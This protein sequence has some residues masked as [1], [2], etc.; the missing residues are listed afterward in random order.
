MEERS[1]RVYGEKTFFSRITNTI[2]KLLIPTKVGINGVLIS[3]KRN[4]VL[5]VYDSY[6]NIDSINNEEKKE[7]I[8][9][10]FDDAYALYLESIDKY[11]MD[12]IYKKVR[13]RTAT[14]FEENALSRYYQIVHI[15]EKEYLEYKYRKQMYLLN[16]DYENVNSG[17]KTQIIEKYKTLYFKEMESLYKGLLK[18]F[19]IKLADNLTQANKEEI[20]NKIFEALEEYIENIL[21]LKFEKEKD[22]KYKEIIEEYENYDKFSVG[23]LD[24][25]DNIEKNMLLLGLSRKLFTHSLPLIVAEQCYEKLLRDLRSLIVDT[26]V[27]K[28]QEKAYSLLIKLIEEYNIKLLSTKIYWDKPEMRDE[29]K[30]FWDKYKNIENLKDTNKE[31][32]IKQ[33]QILFIKDELKKVLEDENKY[34]KIIQFYKTKLVELGAMKNLKKSYAIKIG[35]FKKKTLNNAKILQKT[36][37]ES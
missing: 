22:K 10:K 9:K 16:L 12:S 1:L 31:E 2:T 8:R 5:K 14:D 15:K 23:K 20:Y 33:K 6:E 19:S 35:K 3:I 13:N 24:Q 32:Y 7:N 29:Y 11:I 37:V 28:K 17:K 27:I 36:I 30:K 4:N 18:H 21:P 34:Y 25:N 26:K